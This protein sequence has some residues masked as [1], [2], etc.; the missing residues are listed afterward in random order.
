MQWNEVTIEQIEDE[1]ARVLATASGLTDE[2]LAGPSL[3][4][5][6][7]RGHVLTHLARNADGLARVC[8]AASTGT[9]GS[10][11]DSPAA[12]DADIEAGAR[13]PLEQQVTDL[14]ASALRLTPLLTGIDTDRRNVRVERTPGGPMIPVHKVRFMRLRELVF[15]HV[16]LDA[17]HGF[18]DVDPGI[19]ALC[20]DD[21]VRRLG[22]LDEV[23]GLTVRTDEGEVHVVGDG[24]TTV[25]GPGAAVLL[26]LAREITPGVTFAG[27]HGAA[28][29]ALPFGG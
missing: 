21:A 18:P 8:E 12:R 2:A 23:P 15:H 19:V 20:I 9:A 25:T 5:G 28:A 4:S 24:A 6:W 11:Y 14:R 26:W 1:T 29:P 17:G 10:M 16:D 3:C 22:H 27:P 13:R 7:S